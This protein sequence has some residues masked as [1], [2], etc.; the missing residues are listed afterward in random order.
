M[1]LLLPL[2]LLLALSFAAHRVSGFAK[3]LDRDDRKVVAAVAAPLAVVVAVQVLGRVS[4]V[5]RELLACWLAAVAVGACAVCAHADERDEDPSRAPLRSWILAAVSALVV[6]ALG[7]SIAAAALLDT[8]A[9]DSLGYHLPIAHDLVQTGKLREVP[10]HLAYIETYPRFADLFTAG[11]RVLLGSERFVDL[12]Q[13]PF[14]PLLVAAAYRHGRALG[15]ERSSALAFALAP[16]AMPIVFL[17]CATSYVDVA[18]ASLLVAGLGYLALRE[19]T[20]H[21]LLAALFL[22]L[23][24]A[25]K[26][27]APA[28]LAVAFSCAAA[29]RLR[30]HGLRGLAQVAS[31]AAGAL[32]L[33]GKVYLDNVLRFGNPVWPIVLRAGRFVLPGYVTQE[34]ILGLG[35]SEAE[36]HLSWGAKLAT[37]WFLEPS[38]PVFDMRFGGFGRA[39]AFA[40]LPLAAFAALRLPRARA[41]LAVVVPACLAQSGAFTTRYTITVAVFAF[42]VAP[43]GLAFLAPRLRTP[44]HAVLVAL[45]ASSAVGGFRG[46]SDGGP[47]LRALAA[48]E[49]RG[50]AFAVAPDMHGDRWTDLRAALR[51]GDAFGYDK[52]FGLPSF[53]FRDDGTTRLVFLGDISPTGESL[54]AIVEEGRVRFLAVDDRVASSLGERFKPVFPCG[55]DACTVYEA[56]PLPRAAYAANDTRP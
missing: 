52:S 5:T 40:A 51:P 15:V 22:G 33:G 39:F 43:L 31:V 49:P 48:M 35:L 23:A 55:F 24:L 13:V 34:H 37:S 3:S 2:S 7:G 29:L 30:S 46:F 25:T 17:Q 56:L 19:R 10:G 41:L 14:L 47:S 45:L 32:L 50:R 26:P 20:A 11:F 36:K 9:W 38:S 18:Y 6:V 44:A 1:E 54:D 8:W 16:L 4:H 28:T 42:A 12:S 53:A 21:D 27:S